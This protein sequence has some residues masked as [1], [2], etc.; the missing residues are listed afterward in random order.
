MNIQVWRKRGEGNYPIHQLHS[1]SRSGLRHLLQLQRPP[2][3]DGVSLAE[4]QQLTSTL[5][6]NLVADYNVL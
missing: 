2:A 5:N 3:A 4:K 1:G 6:K